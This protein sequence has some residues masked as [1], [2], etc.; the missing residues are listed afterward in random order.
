M[1][2]ILLELAGLICLVVAGAHVNAGTA[3]LVAGL[4]LVAKAFELEAPRRKTR[5][6]L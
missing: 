1:P 4:V 3:W 6:P 5:R 2:T